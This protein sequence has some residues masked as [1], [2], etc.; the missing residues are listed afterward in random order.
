MAGAVAAGV[1]LVSRRL[2]LLAT[3]AALLMAFTRVYVGAHYPGDVAIGLIFGAVV[4][5]LGYVV[6]HRVLKL[7][8]SRLARTPARR[9]LHSGREPLRPWHEETHR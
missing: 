9:L 8:V 2:G 6:L 1:W 3:V 7:V 5:L 4:T